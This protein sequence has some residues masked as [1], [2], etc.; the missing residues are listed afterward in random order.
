MKY[1]VILA[2]RMS[3]SRLPGK[4]MLSMDGVPIIQGVIQRLKSED[5][6]Y[7]ICL[8]T[9]DLK[10]DDILTDIAKMESIN[11]CRGSLENVLERFVQASELYPSD[12]IIRATG[13][14]PFIHH[15]LVKLVIDFCNSQSDFDLVT[16]KPS[17]PSGIDLEVIPIS[18]LKKISQSNP[19]SD[20]CEH[21]FN[22]IYNRLNEYRVVRMEAPDTWK[23][24]QQFLLDSNEDVEKLYSSKGE[25]KFPDFTL[26]E[27][28]VKNDT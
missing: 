16:T 10:S 28:L 9:S 6:S 22:F 5:Q 11:V 2:A 20:E 25:L 3:S 14:C 24:D 19:T 4:A 13:D 17:F 12:Y 23:T 1:L 8:A 26:T 27:L 18:L 21:I 15:E 7:Q